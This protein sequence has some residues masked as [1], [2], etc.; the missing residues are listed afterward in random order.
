M[1]AILLSSLAL[2]ITFLCSAMH[3]E[4]SSGESHIQSTPPRHT[5]R[6]S[7][8]FS[9]SASPSSP[10]MQEQDV[11]E[12][13]SNLILNTDLRRRVYSTITQT[14]DL[15]LS[16]AL[17]DLLK[18]PV[19]EQDQDQDFV[20][21]LQSVLKNN[22]STFSSAYK[23]SSPLRKGLH[24]A[25]STEKPQV[26]SQRRKKPSAA[27]KRSISFA[28]HIEEPSVRPE[29]TQPLVHEKKPSEPATQSPSIAAILKD[30]VKPAESQSTEVKQNTPVTSQTIPA[31]AAETLP[32]I[33]ITAPT[34][35]VAPVGL[36]PT[37]AQEAAEVAQHAHVAHTN[38]ASDHIKA[39]HATESSAPHVQS[40]EP[41]EDKH[42]AK[43]T[44]PR[45]WLTKKSVITLGL[46]GTLLGIVAYKKF[47]AQQHK[48]RA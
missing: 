27:H 39:D 42:T 1:N 44:K 18:E 12:L 5:R 17:S 36:N 29:P 16:R 15:Q 4:S 37:L 40:Q 35:P 8:D 24:T 9:P 38:E 3:D 45:T 7:L 28:P 30:A 34:E 14:S 6:K 11:F 20:Q 21:D 31:Q 43:D 33:K 19:E 26:T 48:E 22:K 23:P 46:V 32:E 41:Q 10:E 2:S 13:N 25:L 47:S